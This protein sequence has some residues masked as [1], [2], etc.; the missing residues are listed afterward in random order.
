MTTQPIPP[1]IDFFQHI[2]DPRIERNKAY[3]LL[4]VIVITLLAVMAF[5]EGWEDIETYGKSKEGWLK[6]FLPL[7]HGIPKHDV[8]RRVFTRLKPEAIA[9][10]FMEWVRA[11]KRDIT[12]EV[13]AI[14]GKTVRGSFNTRTGQKAIHL[15]SAWATENRLVFA[16]VKTGE[17]ENEITA[18]PTLLEMIALKGCIVTI[19][20][21]GCQYKIAD[22]IVAAGADYLFALKENQGTLY[23]DVKT[24]FEDVDQTH[25]DPT[26]AVHTT[27]DVDHGRIEKRF[28]GITSDVSWLIERHPAWKSI[29]SIGMIDSKREIG[30]K[31]SFERRL[32]VSSL[33]PD[34][35]LFAVTG[36]AHWG[37]EN[38]LHY[39]LD[40]A[41][42]EDGA[43]IKSGE[44]PENWG[45]FRKIAMTV[46]RADRESKDS[47]K[48]RV[49]QMAWSDDY[50]ER[51]LFHSSFACEAGA[52][53]SS[54]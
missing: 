40:V 10:C 23:E 14:D 51:L 31:V 21:M 34:P 13:I 12:R 1:L 17:K 42:R 7:E 11:I 37:I 47:V 16:Q 6:K 5:A 45:Y 25:P 48:S 54:A 28:H 49:K 33:P 39:V 38:S 27:F 43:R 32:Y 44:G 9:S 20:A 4:E 22:Q 36:R 24:Y 18:I 52:A 8:Y 35:E 46:A 41:Y 15:V 50:L 53:A 26:V 3:P 2:K 30:D 19:D 29:T